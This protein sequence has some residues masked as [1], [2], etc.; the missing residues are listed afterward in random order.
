MD[1]N[2]DHPASLCPCMADAPD[3]PGEVLSLRIGQIECEMHIEN[4]LRGRL[5]V[6]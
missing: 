6:V 4:Q 2:L 1:D 5:A 3:K